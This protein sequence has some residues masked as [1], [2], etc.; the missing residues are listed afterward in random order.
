MHPFMWCGRLILGGL[1]FSISAWAN[2]SS[3]S[4]KLHQAFSQYYQSAVSHRLTIID[5]QVI[6]WSV[7][8]CAGGFALRCTISRPVLEYMSQRGSTG[9]KILLSAQLL[10]T[11]IAS[12]RSIAIEFLKG[13]VS[14]QKDA[15]WVTSQLKPVLVSLEKPRR[16]PARSKPSPN[17]NGV[18]LAA[19]NNNESRIDNRPDSQATLREELST[20]EPRETEKDSELGS[21]SVGQ[22]TEA[23]PTKRLLIII[24]Q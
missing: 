13:V 3:S 21:E 14:E 18:D 11:G 4:E 15:E 2:P 20:T 7:G 22:P 24:E 23:T 5:I 19:E 8:S 10:E 17:A 1:L 16:K 9:A 12:D 6:S